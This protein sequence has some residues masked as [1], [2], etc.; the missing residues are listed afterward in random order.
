MKYVLNAK[1]GVGDAAVDTTAEV[2][3]ATKQPLQLRE[4]TKY[5]FATHGIGKELDQ[6]E[7]FTE[8]D[9]HQTDNKVLS[10]TPNQPISRIMAFYR[11]RLDEIGFFTTTKTPKAPKAP[12]APKEVVLGEDGQ[13]VAAAPKKSKKKVLAEQLS[14]SEPVAAD[15]SEAANAVM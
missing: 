4:I 7:L 11:G 15:T 2:I 10:K 14:A 5:V 3:M 13:P 6:V 12:K 8:L 1:I 9:S